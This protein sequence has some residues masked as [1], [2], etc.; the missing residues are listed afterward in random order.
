M[1]L[2]YKIFTVTNDKSEPW[3][4]FGIRNAKFL[5]QNKRQFF[6]WLER[7]RFDSAQ[8]NFSATDL[9]GKRLSS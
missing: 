4:T 2:P 9:I 7:V 3:L 1:S 6:G 8:G 5:E